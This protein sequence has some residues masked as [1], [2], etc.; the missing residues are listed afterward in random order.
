MIKN[1]MTNPNTN[2]SYEY[3]REKSCLKTHVATCFGKYV[4][5]VTSLLLHLLYHCGDLTYQPSIANTVMLGKIKCKD[6]AFMDTEFCWEYFRDKLNSNR[7]DPSLCRE[8]ALA[9]HCI[10]EKAMAN[11]EIC[12]SLVRDHYNPFCANKSDPLMVTNG[13]QDLAKPLPCSSSSVYKTALDCERIFLKSFMENDKTDCGPALTTLKSCLDEQ[14]S[15]RCKD[16]SNN[17]RIVADIRKAVM[18]VLRGPRFFCDAV[19]LR[20]ID[21][22]FKARP[23]IPCR[24]N[25]FPEMEKCAEPV[26]TEFNAQNGIGGEFCSKF[27]TALSC[28]NGVQKSFCEFDESVVGM[29]QRSYSS[30]CVD[31]TSTGGEGRNNTASSTS[32]SFAFLSA[33]VFQVPMLLDAINSILFSVQY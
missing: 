26:R 31:G 14:L 3:E 17:R 21:L 2:C 20:T 15:Q 7:S 33:F 12:S 25:F 22:D 5:L 8:Y 10:N 6:E 28:S 1:L 4:D 9:K 18:A 13:C 11:C 16:D 24:A 32:A 19:N 29:I 30:F 23:T 27:R